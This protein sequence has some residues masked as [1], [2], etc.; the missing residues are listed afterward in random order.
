[1]ETIFDISKCAVENQVKF[2]TCTLHGVTLTW[3]KSYVRTVGQD[4]ANNMPWSTL[5]KLMTIKYCPR[6]EIQKLEAEMWELKVKGTDLVSYTQLF[7]ELALLCERMFLEESDK[8]EKYVGGIP[9]MIYKSVMA[10]KPLTMQDAI[11]FATGLMDKKIHTFVERQDVTWAYTTGPGKKKPYRGLKPLCTKCDYHHKG[12]CAP[13]CYKCGKFGHQARDCK[14]PTNT[15]N[16]RSTEADKKI[17]C[18]ECGVEGHFKRESPKMRNKNRGNHSRNGNAPAK[19]FPEDLLGIPPTQQV[20]F[21]IHLIPGVAPV[22]RAPYRLA[23]SEMKE[24]S[25]QLQELFDKGFIR[26]S[27]SPWGA[28]VFYFKK[29]DGSFWMCIDYWELNKLTVKNRYPLPMMTIGLN[30]TK[31]IL[32]AQIKAQKLKNIKNKDVG[33]MIKKDIPEERLEPVADGTLCLNGRSWLPCNGDL[34]TLIMHEYHKSKYSIHPGS[35]KM[36]QDMNK[37]YWWPNMKANNAT[38]IS[39]CLTSAKDNI[40]MDFVMKLPKS[41]Q[42]YDT[43][44]VIVDRLT[45]TTIF[46]PMRETDPIEKLAKMYLRLDMSTAYHLETNGQNEST[47]QTLEDMLHACVGQAQLTGPELAQETIEK[48]IQIKQ[49]IQVVR[50]RQKSYADLKRKP[51][52][53]QVGYKVMLKVS[54][55]KGVVYFAKRGKLNPRYVG[56][57]K[58]LDK[59][60]DVSYKLKLPQKLIRVHNTFHVS[61]L[62]KCHADGPLSVLLD[63]LKFDDK[64][65]FIEEPVEI[66]DREVT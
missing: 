34:R 15:N 27:F 64:L 40:T 23:P 52:E 41:S 11:E 43:I 13:K 29:K 45:K 5:M 51:M 25:D 57:F 50:D 18:F 63:G 28:P 20:E 38:Y 3:W 7:Q 60:G 42:G 1:M 31:K 46:V 61:K 48:I 21:H 35:D 8:I 54:P 56:P 44:W 9:D 10:S 47:I 22:A 39:K 33:G 14:N 30:L 53:F 12:Q 2:A 6:N 16:Q 59:V 19:V 62:K 49:M 55:W 17:T 65:H 37:L 4:I 66:I 36:Y 24:L 26:P 32:E 58:L